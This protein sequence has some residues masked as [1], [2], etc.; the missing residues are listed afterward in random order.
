MRSIEELVA[1]LPGPTAVAMAFFHKNEQ[2]YPMK[3]AIYNL[4]LTFYWWMEA[5]DD[6][7]RIVGGETIGQGEGKKHHILTPTLLS[8]IEELQYLKTELALL[9]EGCDQYLANTANPQ[10]VEHKVRQGY[11]NIKEAGFAVDISSLYYDQIDGDNR[12]RGS[13]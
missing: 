2:L 1:K 9:A 6:L 3:D 11:N 4:Q 5:V 10:I 7:A 13:K 12:E 8:P